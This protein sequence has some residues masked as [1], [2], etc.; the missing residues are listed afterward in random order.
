MHCIVIAACL[1][2]ASLVI[3]QTPPSG[4]VIPIDGDPGTGTQVGGNCTG[5]CPPV[6]SDGRSPVISCQKTSYFGK[7]IFY[8]TYSNGERWGR[9]C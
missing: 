9:T 8:C 4:P 2:V 3:P 6:A 7:C 5:Q 1:N